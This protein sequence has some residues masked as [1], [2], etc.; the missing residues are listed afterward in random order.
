M[1]RIVRKCSIAAALPGLITIDQVKNAARA[2]QERREFDKAEAERYKKA[3]DR[4]WASLP[5]GYD[6]LRDWEYV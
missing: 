1:A 3:V 2:V 6:W 5:E 4:M